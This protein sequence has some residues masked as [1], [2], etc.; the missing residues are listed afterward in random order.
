MI[1]YGKE[2]HFA[3]TV[4]AQQQIAKL[5]PNGDI[6]RFNE[7]FGGE[8]DLRTEDL[9]TVAKICV[10]MS[11]AYE[12]KKAFSDL[13]YSRFP[14]TMEIIETLEMDEFEQLVN[15]AIVSY[16]RDNT[17]TVVTEPQKKTDAA[18]LESGS[19]QAGTSTTDAASA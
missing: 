14:I 17:P 12:T 2:Y 15:E 8:S 1:I 5:C 7:L 9:D 18:D 19:T 4:W 6:K 11:E 3:L 16:M 10:I 13:E